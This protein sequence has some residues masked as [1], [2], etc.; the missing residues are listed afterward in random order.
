MSTPPDPLATVI[1]P[2]PVPDG[3]RR[4]VCE[5]CECKLT[6]GGDVLEFSEKAKGFRKHSQTVEE[7]NGT[8]VTLRQ[9][10]ETA[11]AKVRDY[12]SKEKRGIKPAHYG[13]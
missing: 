6:N 7:L 10:K 5:F 4:I 9:E 8:I 13:A 12:Q 1:P 2:A 3:R 11:D